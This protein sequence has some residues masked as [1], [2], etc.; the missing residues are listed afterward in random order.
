MEILNTSSS[1]DGIISFL[2]FFNEIDKHFDKILNEEGFSPY[3][4][5]LK[6]ISEGNYSISWF[7]RKHIYQLR[8]FGELRNFIT[9]GI[10]S[11]GETFAMPTQAAI[12]KISKYAK[13]IT[14]P[15]KVL[16]FFKKEVFKAQKSDLLKIIIPQ[17][18]KNGYTNIPIYDEENTF[19]GILSEARLLYWISDLLMNEDY[20]N[21]WLMKVEH[22]QLEYGWKD[23]LFI[24]KEMTIF[25]VNELFTQSKR[26]GEKLSALF[27]TETGNSNEEI[28]GMISSGDANLIDEYLIM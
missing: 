28:Q 4:E 24:S 12:E 17:M 3:N 16:E 8:N 14:K 20:I 5:K 19:L 15:A 26:N 23:Y 18:K 7:V 27:I 6:K 1:E 21:L 25:E 11:N 22:I 2:A 13:M 9:H 10:K